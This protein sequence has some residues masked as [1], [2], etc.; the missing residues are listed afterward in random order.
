MK[1]VDT[2]ERCAKAAADHGVKR[3]VEVSTAQVYKPDKA[4][5]TESAPIKPWTTQANKRLE[6]EQR[7]QKTPGLQWVI[8]RPAIVYGTGDLTGLSQCTTAHSRHSAAASCR[9]SS[10][11]QHLTRCRALL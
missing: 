8:L 9:R 1:C 2:A 6:A 10:L 7:V 4:A 11:M 3:W 5:S